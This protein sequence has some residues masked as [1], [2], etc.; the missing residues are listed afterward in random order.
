[1]Q[2]FLAL[3]RSL[4][5]VLDIAMPGFVALLWLGRFPS[6]PVLALCLATALA[7]YTAIY[8]LNDLIGVK[9][10]Q[11]KVAG[12]ITPGYAVEASAMRYPLAQNL[13]SMKGALAWFGFW[14]ALAVL[15]TWLL[16]P[17]ILLIVFAAAALEV[18]YVKL[19][20]VTWW[21]TVVSGLV[22]SAGPVA[23]VF[24]VIPA[25]PWSGLLGMLIWL[26]LW[27]IG[28]QNIPA[29]WNDLEEDRRIG[30]RTIPL[31]LGLRTAS[32]LV[33]ISLGLTVLASALLPRLSPLAGGW[34]F[35]LAILAAGAG[36]LLPA[37]FR[38]ARTL[39][40]RQ[41]AR[42]FDRASLYPLVLLV[43]VTVFVLIR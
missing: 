38:L 22:K 17:M 7:G 12:G 39:D 4:H 37:A 42:L 16:N 20:K 43:I 6:W 32:A 26:M 29:D 36:L 8:A 33:A 5:G 19:L 9:D 34:P 30:A 15:G 24:A 13:I 18:V 1:M 2:R 41:A 23:A 10:D 35:Q 27:E 25:P 11:E 31:V 40:G 28:G 14:F 21:R 3:S